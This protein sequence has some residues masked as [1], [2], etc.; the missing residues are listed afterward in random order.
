MS[1]THIGQNV[2]RVRVYLGVKQ[3]ALA[4]ELGITQQEVSKIEKQE[5]IDERM[6]LNIADVL[7][8]SP[9]VIRNF[10]LERA[11]K[12]ICNS[13]YEATVLGR[14]S[15]NEDEL[16]LKMV[17]KIFE[18]YERLLKSEREKIELLTLKK[19]N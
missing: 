18:L 11:I 7:C 10:D 19:N 6:L 5:F 1:K 14:K 2:Q 13:D 16:Q 8:I 9:E 3:D 17:E 15:E 4:D 12:N